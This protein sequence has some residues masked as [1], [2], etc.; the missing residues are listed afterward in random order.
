MSPHNL[1]GWVYREGHWRTGRDK[2]LVFLWVS[3][4]SVPKNKQGRED[5]CCWQVG[6]DIASDQIAHLS[7]RGMSLG[8]RTFWRDIPMC[9]WGLKIELQDLTGP[10]TKPHCTYL[11]LVWE[12]DLASRWEGVRLPKASGKSPGFPGSSPNF[13]GSFS[14]TSPNFSHC[15]GGSPEVSQTSPDVPRTFPGSCP[16]FPRGPF[17]WEAWHPLLTHQSFLFLVERFAVLIA[18]P[19]KGPWFG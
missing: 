2:V 10:N 14:A 18:K 17:L 11:F 9:L 15:G 3:L 12:T 19:R 1:G 7:S 4:L 5:Q 8:C 13:P 16:D 6:F